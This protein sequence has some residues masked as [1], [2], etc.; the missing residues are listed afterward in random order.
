MAIPGLKVVAVQPIDM[1]GLF[2]AAVRDPDP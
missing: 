1:V 2:A